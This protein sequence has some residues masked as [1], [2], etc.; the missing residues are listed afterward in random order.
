MPAPDSGRA[1]SRRLDHK[2]PIGPADELKRRVVS[3]FFLGA[4]AMAAVVA[5]PV[6]FALLVVVVGTVMSWEW[7]QMVRF[8]GFVDRA[9]M[10]HAV[11]LA[12]AV[13]ATFLFEPVAV[14]LILAGGAAV[15]AAMSEGRS[16]GMSA[17]GVVYTGVPAVALVL[18][19]DAEP[20][21]LMAVVFVF[22]VTW[23]ADSAAFIGG[24]LIRGPLLYPST[25]PNKTWA[26]FISAIAAAGGM[27]LAV[28]LFIGSHP[29]HGTLAAIALGIAGQLGDL[30]ESA[31]KRMF[32]V[33]DASD[34]IPGHGGFL[35]RMDAIVAAGTLALAL[36]LMINSRAPAQGLL[37]G[38]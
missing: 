36:G 33:K 10:A 4:C 6:P 2:T 37:F 24:R 1:W 13:A 11:S 19:R 14:V 35:D 32:H 23:A 28:A 15:V 26:G 30:G 34:L 18:L 8:G 25:S 29:L 20:Y 5:G 21:G 7:G 17:L 3:A 9:F 12:S 22:A 38:M 31:L 16:R 27:G